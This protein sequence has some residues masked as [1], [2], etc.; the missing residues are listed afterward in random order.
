MSTVLSFQQIIDS[1]ENLSLEDQDYLFNL[2]RKRRIEQRRSEIAAN[3]QATIES[4]KKG[5][6]KRGTIDDLI[7]D[8]LN[9]DDED[10]NGD[11]LG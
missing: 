3:A 7:A 9:D 1:I 8:L 4:F 11:K 5:T 10:N 2:I 6:T